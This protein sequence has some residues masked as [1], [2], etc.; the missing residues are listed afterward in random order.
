MECPVSLGL[1][2]G[3]MTSPS[4]TEV[5]LGLVVESMTGPSETEVSPGTCC[6]KHDRS[7]RD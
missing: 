5:S 7:E 4:E 6:G 3:S 2:V 1:V